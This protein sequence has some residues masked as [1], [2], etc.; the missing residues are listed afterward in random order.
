MKKNLKKITQSLAYFLCIWIGNG[1]FL[2]TLMLLYPVRWW[3]NLARN[4]HWDTRYETMGVLFLIFVLIL[5][6]YRIS[7]ALFRWQ[8]TKQNGLSTF[9]S[10]V[11]PLGLSLLA[12]GLLLQPN[13][14]NGTSANAPLSKQFFIGSYPDEQKIKQLKEEGFTAI[15]SLLHPAVV[16]FEPMLL[17]EERALAQKY[18]IKLI[19]APMLPWVSNNTASLKRIASIAHQ[20]GGK[21]YI[22]CYLGKDRV[23]LV[24]KHIQAIIG[25]DGV[26]GQSSHR[27]FEEMGHFERGELY[28]LADGVYLSPYPTNEEFLA[29]FLAGNVKSVVN[30]MDSTVN[31][32][33]RRIVEER[34]I[35]E[36]ANLRFSNLSADQ[37][38]KPSALKPIIDSILRLPKPVVIHHWKSD[39]EQAIRFMKAYQQ[40]TNNRII[41][42]NSSHE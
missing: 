14:V 27:T 22:H 7:R 1:F 38:P 37:N 24:K 4:Q 31:E 36:K 19:E 33:Q 5:V 26:Y 17:K 16:P 28:R 21:Y 32:Q 15:I 11:F 23:N 6:S 2:G 9:Y 18:Q 10:T 3:A 30:L 8:L 13:L 40:Q 35:L 20:K 41:H 25:K 42:L 12:L 39:S 34:D 29:F